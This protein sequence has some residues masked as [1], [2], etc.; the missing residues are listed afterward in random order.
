[1]TEEH[2]HFQKKIRDP[3]LDEKNDLKRVKPKDLGVV[4][5]EDQKEDMDVYDGSLE[6]KIE[7][8]EESHVGEILEEVNHNYWGDEKDYGYQYK[9]EIVEKELAAGEGV[10]TPEGRDEL[11]EEDEITSEEVWYMEGR[12]KVYKKKREEYTDNPETQEQW[13]DD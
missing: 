10:Y 13:K 9:K 8:R 6:S 1:M 3:L 4:E 12:D 5:G 7:E 2:S 11:V